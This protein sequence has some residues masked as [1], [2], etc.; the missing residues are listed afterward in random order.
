MAL[1]LRN[2]WKKSELQ[3]R[4][5]KKIGRRTALPP[6]E[7]LGEPAKRRR[8]P[9]RSPSSSPAVRK[10]PQR[11]SPAPARSPAPRIRLRPSPSVPGCGQRTRVVCFRCHRELRSFYAALLA[12]EPNGRSLFATDIA[13]I[14]DFRI[15]S[16]PATKTKDRKCCPAF[17]TNVPLLLEGRAE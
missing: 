16:R 6:H 8:W 12:H 13:E 15:R 17:R 14:I 7:P 2:V 9:S 1:C 11:S 10:M 4:P 3:T 5:T